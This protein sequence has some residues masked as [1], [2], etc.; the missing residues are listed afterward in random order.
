V[1]TSGVID[2]TEFWA[3]HMPDYANQLYDAEAEGEGAMK[4]GR[5]NSLKAANGKINLTAQD[6]KDILQQ[7][8]VVRILLYYCSSFF[9]C[10]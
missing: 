10:S 6:R 7:E 3:A 2:D 9:S 1:E 5:M 4:K 8:P